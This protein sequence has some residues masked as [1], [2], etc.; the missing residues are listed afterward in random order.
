MDRN[1]KTIVTLQIY[2][3]FFPALLS[4]LM[5][6]H[7][8]LDWMISFQITSRKRK[9]SKSLQ[10]YDIYKKARTVQEFYNLGGSSRDIKNDYKSGLCVLMNPHTGERFTHNQL[11]PGEWEKF[12]FGSVNLPV[13]EDVAPVLE[14][15]APHQNLPA[16]E[17]V[18]PHQ[19]RRARKCSLAE[20]FRRIR[21][22]RQGSVE[23]KSVSLI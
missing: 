15:V 23:A 3:G 16:L 22:L 4:L 10:R 8:G 7:A 2:L 11:K 20:A 14:D 6:I 17:D 12:Y 13:L 21:R 18:A 19:R 5:T 1:A 9:N